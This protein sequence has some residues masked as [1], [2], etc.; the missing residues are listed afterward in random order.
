MVKIVNKWDSQSQQVH[1]PSGICSCLCSAHARWGGIA[2]LIL[3]KQYTV[4]FGRTADR[5]QME[6]TKSTT[7]SAQG[8]GMGAKTGL[9][10]LP[11]GDDDVEYIVRRLT[12]LECERLQGL[13]DVENFI[14]I[15]VVNRKVWL[16]Q[17]LEFQRNFA[18][19]AGDRCRKKPKLAGAVGKD[20]LLKNVL[21]AE[22]NLHLNNQ[23]N[24]KHVQ[25]N[26]HI[27]SE[28]NVQA[29]HSLWDKLK[30]VFSVEKNFKSLHQNQNTNFVQQDVSIGTT[31]ENIAS[32]GEMVQRNKEGVMKNEKSGISV[33]NTFGKEII[34]LVKYVEKPTQVME[35]DSLFT[36]YDLTEIAN[37]QGMT[38]TILSYFVQNATHTFILRQ[39][40][41]VAISLGTKGF[42][43]IEFKGKPAPDSKRYKAIGNG[44]AHPCASFVLAQI[45]KAERG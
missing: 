36:I 5:I 45:V 23:K 31:K 3:D 9:Y 35:E 21:Y 41:I 42:T 27:S 34:K 6:A 10:C 25:K 24:N 4:D 30:S 12:P 43:D 33:S 40:E 32:N 7:L 19:Y 39:G 13:P 28:E 15:D 26:V 17:W 1:L 29:E 2:P 8:G 22:R 11:K 16:I 44:M 37:K 14:I 20:R 38:L 18:L